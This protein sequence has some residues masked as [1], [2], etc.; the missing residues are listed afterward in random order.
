MLGK[1]YILNSNLNAIYI[2]F[3][4]QWKKISLWLQSKLFYLFIEQILS[5]LEDCRRF[6]Y[7]SSLLLLSHC[8]CHAFFRVIYAKHS[9]W[10]ENKCIRTTEPS[11]LRAVDHYWDEFCSSLDT[12]NRSRRSS[13]FLPY[14]LRSLRVNRT[15]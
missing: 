15:N 11:T 1:N 13:T 10:S 7:I 8:L 3:G 12:S 2:Q 5:L 6:L 9:R 14:F 4:I